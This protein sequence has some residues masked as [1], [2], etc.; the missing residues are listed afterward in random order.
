MDLLNDLKQAYKHNINNEYLRKYYRKN[1]KYSITTINKRFGSWKNALE[2]AGIKDNTEKKISKYENFE[3]VLL[4][5]LKKVAKLKKSNESLRS[6]YLKNGKHSFSSY[7]IKFGSWSK[8]LEKA[9]LLPK[10]D[11]EVHR[12]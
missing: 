10:N 7:Y 1:G 8:A 5:D 4:N 6:F 3:E 11:K 2:K 12:L 9:G